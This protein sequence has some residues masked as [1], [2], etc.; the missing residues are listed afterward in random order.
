MQ[1]KPQALFSNDDTHLTKESIAAQLRIGTAKK[2]ENNSKYPWF[3]PQEEET[4][5]R[6]KIGKKIKYGRLFY[7]TGLAVVCK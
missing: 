5:V 2:K 6:T 4:T 7:C 3:S 1:N